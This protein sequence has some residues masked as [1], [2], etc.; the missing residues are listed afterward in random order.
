MAA[1]VFGNR[2][3][4]T[5]TTTGTGTYTFGSA[6]TGYLT[7]AQAG[8]GDGLR[9][10]YTVVD[11]L[12]A[13]TAFEVGEGTYTLSGTTITRATIHRR[14][15]GTAAAQS[16]SAGTKYIFLAPASE[17]LVVRNSDGSLT[18]AAGLTISSGGATVTGDI[19]V[20]GEIATT[21]DVAVGGVLEA[22]NG[23]SGTQVVN[24]SQFTPVTKAATGTMTLPNGVIMKWGSSSTTAGVGTVTF[25]TAFPTAC[26]NVQL[27]INSGS[28]TGE[29]FVVFV[30][31]VTASTFAVWGDAG[32]NIRFF[33]QAI[34][35]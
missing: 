12:T 17:R 28:A 13:P 27:T 9:V 18:L 26:R 32:E 30:G 23:T 31:T 33:W 8:V 21:G 4:V 22:D 20:T 15:D 24:Y 6:V 35:D 7:P 1:N 11:S 34:G 14:T 5:T 25:A 10:G 29:Y 2:V 16:W 3:L 19:I